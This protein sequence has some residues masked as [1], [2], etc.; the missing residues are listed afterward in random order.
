MKIIALIGSRSAPLTYF[1]NTINKNHKIDLVI[2]EKGINASATKQ[3]TENSRKKTPISF[4]EK[5]LRYLIFR[6][7]WK[8]EINKYFYKS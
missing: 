5:V 6:I 1:T 8:K 4:L 7:D 2:I 3:P